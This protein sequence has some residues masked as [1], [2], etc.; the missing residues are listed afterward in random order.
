[1]ASR[2]QLGH[3]MGKSVFT[4]A[5]LI[6]LIPCVTYAKER[7]TVV[8]IWHQIDLSEHHYCIYRV[9]TGT[10]FYELLELLGEYPQAF[11]LGD[12]LVFTLDKD[13]QHAQVIGGRGKNPKLVLIN[14]ELKVIK[15]Y[16]HGQC[17]ECRLSVGVLPSPK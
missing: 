4:V 16:P 2:T 7:G 13:H 5:L 1:M 6:M 11:Q 17:G 10:H 3:Q 9:E 8:D 15:K 14:E 12:S